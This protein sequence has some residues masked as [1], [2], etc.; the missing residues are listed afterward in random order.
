MRSERSCEEVRKAKS[1]IRI[2][3]EKLFQN[4]KTEKATFDSCRLRVV[5]LFPDWKPGV[6]QGQNVSVIFNLPVR[7]DLRN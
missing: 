5:K 2:V 1:E 7:F 4:N 6:Y 3:I